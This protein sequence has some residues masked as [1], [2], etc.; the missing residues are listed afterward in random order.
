MSSFS[1]CLSVFIK[2]TVA[3]RTPQGDICKT[4][5]VL[6]SFTPSVLKVLRYALISSSFTKKNSY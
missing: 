3:E 5:A 1:C 4:M 6:H 2:Q